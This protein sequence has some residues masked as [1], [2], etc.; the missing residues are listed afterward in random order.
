MVSGLTIRIDG[1]QALSVATVMELN[2]L[3]ERAGDQDGAAVVVHVSGA[4]AGPRADGLTVSLV[5]KWERA[6]RRLERLAAPTVAIA[7]DDCGAGA[8][9]ALLAT[10]YR[11]A[12]TSAR[13]LMPLEGGAA[14]PGMATYRLSQQAGTARVRKAVLFGTPI[15]AVEALSLHL[16][17]ELVDDPARA[18]ERAEELAGAVSGTELAIRRQ[19]LANAAT[20]SFE[21]ALGTHL[22]ACD[23]AL[24]RAAVAP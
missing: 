24:R 9:D 6:L 13:L 10:D 20:T 23:R 7:S 12:T 8:L 22:A 16:V 17:D 19:L 1:A 15:P 3:C 14:W 4:P 18:L 11:I 21:D 5:S 2:A